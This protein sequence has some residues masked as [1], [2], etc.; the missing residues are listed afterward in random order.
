MAFDIVLGV[1]AFIPG[2]NFIVGVIL[3]LRL[4]KYRTV[5]KELAAKLKNIEDIELEIEKLQNE[6]D[7]K[8]SI[9]ENE[10]NEKKTKLE[11]EY[12]GLQSDKDKSL[13]Q[14]E[15]NI[16]KLKKDLAELKKEYRELQSSV[17]YEYDNTKDYS[18]VTSEEI[19]N[20]LAM[21]KLKEKDL[22]KEKKAFKA[23]SIDSD[24][25]RNARFRQI[26]KCFSAETT[27]IL[28][29]LTL[30]NADK[31]RDRIIKSF[32]TVNKAFDV[33]GVQLDKNILELKLDELAINNELTKKLEQEKIIRQEQREMLKEE[34]KV[35]REIEQEKAKIEKE[36]KQFNGEITKLMSYMQ[37]SDSDV[38]KKLYIDKIKELENK[39]ALLEE[40]K[41]HV[42][43]REQN[44]RA[45]YVYVISNIGS[46]GENIYKI[47][48]TRRLEPMD[49]IKE[50]SSASVPF[51]FDVHAM[52]FSDDAPGLENLLHTHFR[53]QAVNKINPRK[54]F[55]DVD[56]EEV[57]KLVLEHHNNTVDFTME[58]EA[59]EYRESLKA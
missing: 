44:T 14:T 6:Y 19:K 45:G 35:R 15:K 13:K 11:S 31:S 17:I 12:S 20:E 52:I 56:L 38:E 50:L 30:A 51:S 36:E 34:E 4:F 54:E 25:V 29:K 47:G 41:K 21:L 48:V 57:K 7:D 24:K 2:V 59:Y 23:K 8:T 37:K 1:A 10:Y 43:D 42:F 53:D 9:L 40:D 16:E 39:L 28:N 55:F 58:P 33:D 18:D 27:D 49:R 26:T 22:I 46:F 3:L 32:E 5:K